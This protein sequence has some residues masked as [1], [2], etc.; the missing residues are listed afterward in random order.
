M[1]KAACAPTAGRSPGN[2]SAHGP[3]RCTTPG[4][5]Q[6]VSTNTLQLVLDP[7]SNQVVLTPRHL[8]P[9]VGT[10]TWSFKIKGSELSF[11]TVN[12]VV[13]FLLKKLK[14]LAVAAGARAEAAAL[15][16]RN[17]PAA[18]AK[19]GQPAGKA[20][21]RSAVSLQPPATK[22]CR[23][24][25]G[26]Q[27]AAGTAAGAAG[28]VGRPAGATLQPKQQRPQQR[29]KLLLL[30]Q[31]QQDGPGQAAEVSVP[32]GGLHRQ[33]SLV[34]RGDSSS[35]GAGECVVWANPATC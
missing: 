33:P 16:A 31:Q 14:D 10:A 23:P 35:G 30:Q 3:R 6:E 27:C 20:L 21:Q 22:Q 13:A 34:Q 9:V 25:G 12:G 29:R 11:A 32:Q 7:P 5:L 8:R 19:G 28:C 17:N 18:G 1:D 4:P 15:A 2:L 24:A 26:G